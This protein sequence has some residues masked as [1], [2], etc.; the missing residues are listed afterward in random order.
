MKN[1]KRIFF[2]LLIIAFF[3]L[4]FCKSQKT[5][6]TNVTPTISVDT[7]IERGDY[8]IMFYNVENLFDIFDDTLKN[9]DEFLP[10]GEKFWTYNRYLEKLANIAKVVTAIGMWE[11]PEIIGLC[12]IENYY[13]LEGITKFSALKVH[14]YQICHYESPDDRG[15]D[16]ALLYQASKFKPIKTKKVLVKFPPALGKITRDILYVC[17]V[18]TRKDTLHVFVNHWPSRW[19]GMMDS[20]PRRMYAASVLRN[21]VDSIFKINPKANIIIMGDLNDFPT[22]KSVIETLK[23]KTEYNNIISNELYNL[24]Y[25]LQEIKGKFSH[26]YQ[27]EQGILDQMIISGALLDTTANFYTRLNNAHV[28]DADFLLERDENNIGFKPFRTYIGFKFHG[29]YSDHLPVY[30]DLFYQKF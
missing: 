15:I 28:F 10:D 13:V 1:K 12:E 24:A 6:L 23:A 2:F 3:L 29:G 17:G 9:D 16:V 21:E 4:Q 14:D 30:L 25:Y 27:G 8:R 26:K 19:G 18:T 7:L 5:N 20:E 22:N 11:A